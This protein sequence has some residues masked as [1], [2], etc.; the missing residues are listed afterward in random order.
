[1]TRRRPGRGA[2][3]ARAGPGR[4]RRGCEAPAR[5]GVLEAV[6]LGADRAARVL[7]GVAALE[8]PV[9]PQRV[10]AAADVGLTD[11]SV[12]GPDVS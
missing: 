3:G 6:V 5:R 11:A 8:D 12:Y 2:A 10:E 9:L 7:L 4:P 1:M